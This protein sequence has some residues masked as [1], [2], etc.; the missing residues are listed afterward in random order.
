MTNSQ[1]AMETF[2]SLMTGTVP[3]DL[4]TFT[5]SNEAIPSLLS[6]PVPQGFP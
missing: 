5:M 1:S 6:L 2:R 3:K 4:R